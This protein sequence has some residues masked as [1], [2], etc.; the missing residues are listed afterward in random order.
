[1]GH[2]NKISNVKDVSLRPYASQR[3]C[4]ASRG[5]RRTLIC[6]IL[7]VSLFILRL[8]LVNFPTPPRP[9]LFPFVNQ[10]SNPRWSKNSIVKHIC[11]IVRGVV[12][13]LHYRLIFV[14]Q[15]ATDFSRPPVVNY[16][17]HLEVR[18]PWW[19]HR[20]VGSPS[21]YV[22]VESFLCEEGHAALNTMVGTLR[23][24]NNDFNTVNDR[25]KG[26][27]KRADNYTW[28]R[29]R[30][31]TNLLSLR[32][33]IQQ[34]SAVRVPRRVCGIEFSPVRGCGGGRG[35]KGG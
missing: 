11:C 31:Y 23:E 5:K 9:F 12:L 19:R 1:M 32:S 3:R 14:I 8:S 21:L 7:F 26:S 24:G 28:R 13:R 18:G 4:V 29:G 30:K 34:E 2:K 16:Y 15:T 20:V 6:R 35:R 33:S 27:T 25:R 17:L 22:V 10:S